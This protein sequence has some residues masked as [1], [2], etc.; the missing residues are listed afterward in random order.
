M[1]AIVLNSFTGSWGGE[2]RE[3]LLIQKGQLFEIAILNE[4]PQFAV[5]LNVQH[6]MGNTSFAQI[7]INGEKLCNF[8][9][10]VPGV[11]GVEVNG[12]LKHLFICE[13]I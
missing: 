4:Q 7:F 3:R 13:S 9:Q 2:Q 12:D 11:Y 10:R 6:N 8:A 1:Q 5:R